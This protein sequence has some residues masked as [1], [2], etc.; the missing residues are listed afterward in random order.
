MLVIPFPF[1]PGRSVRLFLIDGT[2]QGI[3]TA[4][5]GNWTGLALVCPR[6]FVPGT[7]YAAR[8]SISS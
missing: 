2:P 5:V 1:M 6:T 7:R 8:A 4:E 3:R